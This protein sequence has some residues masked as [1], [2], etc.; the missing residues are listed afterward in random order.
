[1]TVRDRVAELRRWEDSGALWSVVSRGPG[2][3]TVA[4][5]TCDGGEEVDRFESTDPA[6]LA[7]VG[8]R[9]SSMDA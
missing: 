1:M 9:S 8:D 6:V 3:L 5:M 2:R 7:F 4:L